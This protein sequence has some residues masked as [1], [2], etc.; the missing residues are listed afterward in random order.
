VIFMSRVRISILLC[1]L[2][3]Q[4]EAFSQTK[5]YYEVRHDSLKVRVTSCDSMRLVD[6]YFH[7]NNL[8]FPEY[9]VIR[10]SLRLRINDDSP[11]RMLLILSPR[12]QED[13][14][15]NVNC[16]DEI[17]N[18]LLVMTRRRNDKFQ[19]V[20]I[21]P[22]A[23]PNVGDYPED[24]FVR[25]KTAKGGIVLSFL[26]G[27]S[28]KCSSDFFF[29]KYKEGFVLRRLTAHDYLIDLSKQKD[30]VKTFKYSAKNNLMNI[31][32]D[33]YVL[34]LNNKIDL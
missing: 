29:Y 11:D 21:N 18:R 34:D 20:W 16:D 27:S 28:R 3:T 12:S 7:W 23:I 26:T 30:R 14:N 24:A 5:K 19:V 15:L 13:M 9:F 32:L 2:L 8:S 22:K 33:K 10:D 4:G 6:E 31:N 25:M 1:L 17:N